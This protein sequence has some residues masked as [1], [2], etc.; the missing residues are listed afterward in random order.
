MENE[1]LFIQER[2]DV[3]AMADEFIKKCNKIKQD[4]LNERKKKENVA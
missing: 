2:D 4:I 3:L 1:R